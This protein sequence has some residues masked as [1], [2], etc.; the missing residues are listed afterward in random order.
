MVA[1][2]FALSFFGFEMPMGGKV[3]PASILPVVLFSVRN[4]PIAALASG[5][6]TTLLQIFQAY[7]AGNVFVYCQ[8]GATLF[9]CVMFDYVLP[10]MLIPLVA[11]LCFY[12]ARER[13]TT[14]KR[15]S[16]LLYGGLA[17]GL[18]LRF[19]CHYVSG[20]MIWGQWAENMSPALYSLLYNG[21]YM[22]PELLICEALLFLLC[23]NSAEM[24]TRL[25]LSRIDA[26]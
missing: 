17:L 11:A 26:V 12:C 20:V 22:L 8:D 19:V 16:A 9:I 14:G 5:F 1:L 6:M 10:F 23:R 21:A 18:V 4:G 3:T 15:L 24:R 25:G 2:S 13:G 7:M